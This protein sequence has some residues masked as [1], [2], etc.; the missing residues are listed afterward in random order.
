MS[1]S[2]KWYSFIFL[3]LVACFPKEEGIEPKPRENRSVSID[4]GESKN[5][6]VFYSLVNSEIVGETSPEVWDIYADDNGFKL[7]FLRSMRV[8][9][10][11]E[12]WE[13]RLDTIGLT[14]KYLTTDATD[15]L[16]QI[17]EDV[18]LVVDLG[19]ADDY[20][21]LGFMKLIVSKSNAGF[22]LTYGALG[23]AART[24]ENIALD[25]FYYSLI[26]SYVID[27]PS[28]SE[29]DIVFGK[30][31]DFV[32]FTNEEADYLVY[33][34]LLGNAA[35]IKLEKAFE[36]VTIADFDSQTFDFNNRTIIGWDWKTYSLDKGAY[37][38]NPNTTY[39]IETKTGFKY[40]FRFVNFY[41]N[42]G[43]SGHPTFEYKLI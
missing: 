28:E 11:T 39:L 14:F 2:N 27:L 36:D 5:Q 41:N 12:T 3:F 38:I 26:S 30:Y 16:W 8:A 31:T 37:E 9:E 35:A 32:V 18:N 19:L 29:Y 4:A 10:F 33:G 42:Q 6:V 34:V 7:N 40:K 15:V 22:T 43:I 1:L 24:T 25:Y 17:E 23:K 20:T 21:P 13:E